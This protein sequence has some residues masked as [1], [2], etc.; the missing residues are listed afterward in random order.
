[1]GCDIVEP[2]QYMGLYMRINQS[3]N[4]AYGSQYGKI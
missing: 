4:L 1:M 2:K 3:V